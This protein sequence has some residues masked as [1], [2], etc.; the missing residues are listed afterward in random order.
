MDTWENEVEFRELDGVYFRIKRNDKWHNICFS[1]LTEEEMRE[2]MSGREKQWLEELCVILG[3]T[4]RRMG[5]MFNI[6]PAKEEEDEQKTLLYWRNVRI[7]FF[8]E[9]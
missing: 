7:S 5:D 3:K 2:V 6:V 9:S 1:D 4:L 8:S